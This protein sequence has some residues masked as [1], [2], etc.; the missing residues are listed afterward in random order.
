V[1]TALRRDA[2]AIC[3]ANGRDLDAAR[4]DGLPAPLLARLSLDARK[5]DGLV[6]GLEALCA[7]P[8][9]LGRVTL[10]TEL[11]PGLVL[12]RSS[13]PIGTIGVVFESRPDAL[14]QISSLC[15]KSGNACLL[16]GGREAAHTNKVLFESIRSGAAAAGAPDGWIALLES[17]EDVSAMLSL[18]RDIDL[19]IPRGSN[20]FVRKMQES[21]RI[22]VMGHSAGICHLYVDASADLDMAVNIAVDAKTQAP[23]TCNSIE[24]LL[25]HESVARAFLPKLA[26]AMSEKGVELRGDASVRAILPD[27]AAATDQD[28]DE[29]YLALVLSVKT[30]ASVEEAVAHV[31]AHGSRHT[32][33]IVASCPDAA[34]QFISGVDS[35]D[36]FWNCS[37]RF[38]DGFRFGLGAEVGIA[39]G[40]LHARGPVGLEGL[41]TYRWILRGNGHTVAPFADGRERFTH[42]SLPCGG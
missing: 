9:P 10:K 13:C 1:A 28:W 6:E 31:N 15:L 16:K 35:A 34:A 8:D 3:A 5:L 37:T 32:D 38:A 23:A 26:A 2:P 36:A 22:P 29:E 27:C 33:A 14:V 25:V 24:T 4:A 41:T 11:A 39:T 21:T 18:D 42:V 20:A 19:L 30:V 40:K 12:T 7:L 17:R